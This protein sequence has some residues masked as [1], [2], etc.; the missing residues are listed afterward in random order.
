MPA[1]PTMLRAPYILVVVLLTVATLSAHADDWPQWRGPQRDG[2]WHESGLIDKFA[3]PRLEPAWRAEIGSG[4]CGPTVAE[5]RVYVMD[6][7]IEPKQMERVH[8]LD[9]KTGE[10]LWTYAYECPYRN[11]GYDAGPR[12]S[13]TVYDGRA[14][15]L[16]AMGNFHCF[17]ARTG[18]VLWKHDGLTEYGIEMPIWGIASA[19]LIEDDLVIVQLGGRPDACLVAFDRKSGK[20]RWRALADRASYS[21]PIIIE[22]AG[23]RVLV[24]YTGDHVAGLDPKTGKVYWKH[25]FPPTK[26]VIGVA[27]PVFH[28]GFVF[29]TNFFDGAMLLKLDQD[30]LEAK[31][32]WHRVGPSEQDTDGLQ[33]IISTPYLKGDYI[34]GVDSYGEFRCL[35]LAT[36]KRV[37]ESLD[38]TPKARWSTAHIVEQGDRVWIF[39][40]RGE[41]IIARLSPSGYEEISRAKLLEPTLDQLRQRGGVTWSHPAFANGHVFARNDKELVCANLAAKH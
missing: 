22:Q 32:V 33:S 25:P 8:C 27:S 37:W 28:Q 24:A 7:L 39:N 19:P 29:V 41:L 40:E 15:A 23:R 1:L 11:V 4:Y 9:E 12:A 13:V 6:R 30:V 21:A 14:Y 36:G 16:G 18:E 31:E 17:D 10:R 3:G 5:G 38:V 26:M 2:V 35:E 34:Y 20:E